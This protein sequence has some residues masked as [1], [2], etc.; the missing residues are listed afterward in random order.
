VTIREARED[1]M[2]LVRDLFREYARSLQLDL[3]FQDFDEELA[4]LPGKYSRPIGRLLLA[5]A[6]VE[7]AGCVG[8]RPFDEGRCE[9]KRFYV[10]PEH[11]GKRIGE[12]LLGR[13]LE[14]AQRIENIRES[15]SLRGAGKEDQGIKNETSGHYQSVV[16]DTIEPL[17]SKAIAMYKRFGFREIPPYRPNPLRG[18]LYM[19]LRLEAR[20]GSGF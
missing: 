9:M 7:A 4:S 17:M 3:A 12:K 2:E 10:R 18:A 11:R 16:L 15:S 19:E 13:F 8:L 14:E 6:G 1:E 5:F 20:S